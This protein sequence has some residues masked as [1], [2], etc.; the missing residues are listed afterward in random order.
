M[1]LEYIY[2]EKI[3][4]YPNQ[5]GQ[6]LSPRLPP[7]FGRREWLDEHELALVELNYS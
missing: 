1:N 6:K 5:E 3:Q 2:K 4:D 7:R